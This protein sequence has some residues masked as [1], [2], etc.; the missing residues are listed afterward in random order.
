MKVNTRNGMDNHIYNDEYVNKYIRQE[1]VKGPLVS[2]QILKLLRNKEL[3]DVWVDSKFIST[4]LNKNPEQINMVLRTLRRE[5]KVDFKYT[6][7]KRSNRTLI[8]Y[9]S[10]TQ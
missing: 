9:K 1:T 2:S 10:R 5:N 8:V 6:K 3:K 7:S 4:K